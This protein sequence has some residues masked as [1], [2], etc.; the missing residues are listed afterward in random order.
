MESKKSRASVI[1]GLDLII[2][3]GVA[4]SPNGSR[5]GHGMGYYDR[6]FD[7]LFKTFPNRAAPQELRGRIGKKLIAGQTIFIGLAFRQQL[8]DDAQLPLDD[9]DVR[10]DEVITADSK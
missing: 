5:M 6:Y 7:Q 3:P 10:L 8:I 4:F 2:V 1:D 9:H